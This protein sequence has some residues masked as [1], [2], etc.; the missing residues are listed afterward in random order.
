MNYAVDVKLTGI[1]GAS[2][3]TVMVDGAPIKYVSIPVDENYMIETEKGDIFLKLLIHDV[4]PN[5]LGCSHKVMLNLPKNVFPKYN[6]ILALKKYLTIGNVWEFN[7][8]R[9]S[10]NKDNEL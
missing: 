1:R 8:K 6:S 9:N 3:E 7:G 10:F 2:V 5:K 4:K